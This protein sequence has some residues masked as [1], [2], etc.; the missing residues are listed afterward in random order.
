[1]S[2]N[3]SF[4]ADAM[5]GG[6]ARWLRIMGFDTLYFRV[7]EDGEL[8]RIGKQ[9]G[10]ILLSRDHALCR[11]KRT[12]AHILVRSNETMQQ[13]REVLSECGITDDQI[14][15]SKRCPRC[16]GALSSVHRNLVFSGAPEHIMQNADAFLKCGECGKVYWEGSHKRMMDA[17]LEAI[18]K[19]PENA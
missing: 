5:L 8:I 16:N 3:P 6:L 2:N 13:L 10:R 14:Q 9:Q 17:T 19:R 4:I 15:V 11:S 12:G 1:M 7:I 18:I